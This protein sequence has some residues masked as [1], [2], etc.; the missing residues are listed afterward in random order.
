MRWVHARAQYRKEIYL[1][2][3]QACWQGQELRSLSSPRHSTDWLVF[4]GHED[5]RNN[6]AF[7]SVLLHILCIFFCKYRSDKK[8]CMQRVQVAE[9]RGLKFS[10]YEIGN[11]TK[12]PAPAL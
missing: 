10:L 6:Q 1:E 3:P 7:H 11:P 8:F 2:W 12:L 5:K 4:G 9:G